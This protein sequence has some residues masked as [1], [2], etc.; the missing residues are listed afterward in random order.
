[1]RIGIDLDNSALEFQGHWAD[2]Y[3]E[4]FNVWVYP[5]Q[6]DALTSA[7]HFEDNDEWFR[8]ASVAG[9]W[10]D[11]PWVPGACGFIDRA[12]TFGHQVMFLTARNDVGAIQQTLEWFATI[13]FSNPSLYR[14]PAELRT[15]M[16][17][18]SVVPCGIYFDDAP[19]VLEELVGAG[20][21]VVVFDR[22]WNRDVEGQRLYDWSEVKVDEGNVYI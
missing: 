13:P 6:W 15:G 9:V 21:N 4:W 18:K 2:R 5:D 10:R 14:F 1:M 11:M 16:S 17:R 20:K 19:H 8:W 7:T 12:L 3:H 22:P